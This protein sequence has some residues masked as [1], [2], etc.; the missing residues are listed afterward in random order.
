VTIQP[1]LTKKQQTPK[2]KSDL[3]VEKQVGPSLESKKVLLC[4]LVSNHRF[5]HLMVDDLAHVSSLSVDVCELCLLTDAES[6]HLVLSA[7]TTLQRAL[8]ELS[9]QLLSNTP[10]EDLHSSAFLFD[11]ARRLDIHKSAVF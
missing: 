10:F 7:I 2:Q 9:D 4:L 8:Y 6:V 11:A 1:H 5:I 3:R